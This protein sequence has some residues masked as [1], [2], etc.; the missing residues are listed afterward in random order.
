MASV[1]LNVH[2]DG[3]ASIDNPE[4]TID[5]P[6]FTVY[7]TPAENFLRAQAWTH[8]DLPIATPQSPVFTMRW[9]SNW[10]NTYIDVYFSGST[11]PDPP[12]PSPTTA[13]WF[14]PVISK[15]LKKVRR[16]QK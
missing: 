9:V 1:Y 5:D 8:D 10:G 13:A 12:T 14:I 15:H 6:V 2:G 16:M 4:P 11:P 7:C 3:N